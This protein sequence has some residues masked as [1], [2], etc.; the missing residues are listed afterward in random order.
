MAFV[1][2]D[3]IEEIPRILV[4]HAF[5]VRT[6]IHGLIDAEVDR[7]VFRSIPLGDYVPLVFERFESIVGLITQ[8]IP[9]GKKEDARVAVMPGFVPFGLKELPYC[10][11]SYDRFASTSC[12][13]D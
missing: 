7:T 4:E 9:V 3:Q 10:L 6:G 2:N 13:V 11:K 12:K 5:A 1:D 8:N